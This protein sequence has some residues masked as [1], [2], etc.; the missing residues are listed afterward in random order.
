V[1]I[2]RRKEYLGHKIISLL[3]FEENKLEDYNWKTWKYFKIPQI[4]K[5]FSQ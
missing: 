4:K 3:N 5:E 2:E 1:N